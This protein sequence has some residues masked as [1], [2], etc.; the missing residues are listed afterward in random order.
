MWGAK[1][2]KARK[3]LFLMATLIIP[4]AIYLFLRGFG[5]NHYVVPVLFEQGIPKDTADCPFGQS[6]H[7]VNISGLPKNLPGQDNLNFDGK[8]SV[9]DIDIRSTN[10]IGYTGYSLNR[11]TDV[12]ENENSVQFIL[13]GTHPGI[14]NE[15]QSQENKRFI[16]VYGNLEQITAFARCQLVLLDFP[17]NIDQKNR[18][19]VLIDRRGRIRGYYRLNDFSEM[20]RMILEMKIILAEEF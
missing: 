5:E 2:G 11:V 17:E 20:D 6:F 15:K 19:L 1:N 16:Y 13:I 8:L 18:R 9:I 12:F 10:R 7:M 4:V 14:V 3:L